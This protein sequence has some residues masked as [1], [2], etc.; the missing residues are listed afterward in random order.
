ARSARWIAQ[1]GSDSGYGLKLADVLNHRFAPAIDVRP[2]AVADT[3][4]GAGYVDHVS[5]AARRGN[6]VVR[7]LVGDHDDPVVGL[8]HHVQCASEVRATVRLA[9]LHRVAQSE[10][11]PRGN[12][13]SIRGEGVDAHLLADFAQQHSETVGRVGPK[14]LGL[15]R[16]RR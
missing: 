7:L 1:S 15:T 5:L 13:D 4:A 8:T 11:A 3:V 2:C 14:H 12:E 16:Q 6:A 10:A 9:D